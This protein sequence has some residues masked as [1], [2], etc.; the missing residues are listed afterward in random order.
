MKAFISIFLF[1]MLL[2]IGVPESCAE[3][4]AVP[5]ASPA[6]DPAM[7]EKMKAMMAPTEAHKA[8]EDFVGKWAYT[9]KFWMTAEAPA[10][11]M[12]GTA[13][14][15]LIYGGRFLKQEIEGPWMG[16]QFEG[17][18]FTGYDNIQGE[19]QTVWLDSMATGMMKVS[20]Q[21]DPATK[22]LS[23]SGTNSCPLTGEKD[24]QG[25]SEWTVTDADH[26]VY[27]SYSTGADGKEFKT[28][29]ITYTR[30]PNN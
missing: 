3:D 29:E 20:G 19:Y 15:T 11:D 9:G 28:M 2:A 4:A 8:L 13:E 12:T 17:L 16:E 26:S 1:A 7:M 6:M 21:Y 18:G 22:T 5:A 10:Q 14:H 23:Q 24:R 30:V 25:R 27:T